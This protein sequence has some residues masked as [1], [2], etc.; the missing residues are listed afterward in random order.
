MGNHS[1]T[2]TG[3][4]G[5]LPFSP[6]E[7]RLAA[8]LGERA[9]KWDSGECGALA[10]VG[11]GREKRKCGRREGIRNGD[12]WSFPARALSECET[13]SMP[14]LQRPLPVSP[15]SA[16]SFFDK[17]IWLNW[18][19]LEILGCYEEFGEEVCC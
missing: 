16:R 12:G 18:E 3:E 13:A 2:Q 15:F 14:T 11:E 4:W 1:P 5:A 10:P 9:R 6:R 7:C 17:K 8:L 19:W